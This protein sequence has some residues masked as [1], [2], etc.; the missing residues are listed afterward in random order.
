MTNYVL[1]LRSVSKTYGQDQTRFEALHEIDLKLTKRSLNIIVGPSGSGKSTLINLASLLDTPSQGKILIKD[2]DLTNL[3]ESDRSKFRRREIGIIYQR[4]NLFTFLNILENVMT[5]MLLKDRD[6]AQKLLN[7][8]GIYDLKKFP[9]ELSI[10]DQQKITLS[11]ALINE[12]CLLLADEP[13]GELN[14][15]D[16]G[17]I[18]NLFQELSKEITIILVSNNQDLM[19]YCDNIFYLKD[20]FL[21]KNL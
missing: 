17:Q 1:E 2:H 12:P 16:Q 21:K 14:T 18:M 11:R 15:H 6:K 20:G 4:D 8:M 10:L 19:K 13:T 5:P 9:E 3:G 7:K